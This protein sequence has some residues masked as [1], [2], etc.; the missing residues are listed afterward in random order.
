MTVRGIV[1]C[2]PDASLDDYVGVVE[3]LIQEGFTRFAL[4]ATAEALRDVTTIFGSRATFGAL[5][6]SSST[7]VHLAADAGAAFVF[8]DVADSD[9]ADAADERGV[10]CFG[11][12]MT[13]REVRGALQLSNGALLHP[14]DVV[15]HA[16]AARLRELGL[17][18]RVIPLGGIGA[19]AAGEW[20]KAGAP[21]VG[22]DHTLLG[23]AFDGGSLSQLRE[24]CT[25][26][27]A[28]ERRIV[29]ERNSLT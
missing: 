28:L 29:E 15:G 5:R 13:P 10:E 11:S 23:D 24:R 8:S 2:L 27:I 17:A 1:V 6:V 12:A 4:P 22:I 19:Y 25:S 14:A 7:H 3:V 9:V 16:M 20:F 26:F 21:A 18:D